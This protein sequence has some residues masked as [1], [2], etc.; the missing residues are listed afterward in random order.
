[1]W[2]NQ[3]LQL[4]QNQTGAHPPAHTRTHTYEAPNIGNRL[5]GWEDP[6]TCGLDRAKTKTVYGGIVTN[7]PKKQWFWWHSLTRGT[8]RRLLGP[9]HPRESSLSLSLSLIRVIFLVAIS[10]SLSLYLSLSLALSLS[11]SLSLA[12]SRSLSLSLSLSLA[13]SVSLS[14]SLL[15]CLVWAT[16]L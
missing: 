7:H 14:L 16:D 8:R 4:H 3:W 2:I 10:L 9:F 11:L 1:M 5:E 15:C 12:L 6:H 13:L